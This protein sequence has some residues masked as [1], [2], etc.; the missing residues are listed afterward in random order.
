MIG[1]NADYTTMPTVLEGGPSHLCLYHMGMMVGFTSNIALV[2]ETETVVAILANA[3]PLGDGVDWMSQMILE[4]IH[5]PPVKHNYEQLAEEVAVKVL[6]H[7]PS[8]GRQLDEKRLPGTH[9]SFPLKA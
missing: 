3:T 9:P 6:G 7:I 8:L 4:A 5:E 1:V 2:P